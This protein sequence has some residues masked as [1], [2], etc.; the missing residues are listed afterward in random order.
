MYRK[1][2]QKWHWPGYFVRQIF[3]PWKARIQCLVSS[4]ETYNW[5]WYISATPPPAHPSSHRPTDCHMVTTGAQPLTRCFALLRVR[6]IPPVTDRLTNQP[7]NIIDQSPSWEGNSHSSSQEIPFL[8][9]NPK[10][11]YS[12]QKGPPL[13]P[14]VNQMHPVHT[15]PPH[16]P[17]IHSNIIFIS[18][19]RL[20]EL[21]FHFRFSN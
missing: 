11:R 20:S 14:I 7:T 13:V 12:V 5:D 2:S 10:I 17:T 19:P 15:L 3:V 6:E 21:S 4:H 9:W 8:L 18:A 16:F 1:W